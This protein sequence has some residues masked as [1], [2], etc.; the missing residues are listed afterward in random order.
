MLKRD[1]AHKLEIREFIGKGVVIP[2]LH[3]V[4]CKSSE[5][6]LFV[7]NM[8]NKNRTVGCTRMNEHSSRSHAIFSVTI[9]MCNTADDSFKVGKLNLIDLAGSERQSKTGASAERL[10]EASKINRALSALGNVISALAENSPHIPYRDS[11]LT[12]LLQDSLGGNSKTIM[13]ANISPS[14]YNYEESLTTLR[15]AHRAKTIKN[16]PIKN[17]DPKDVKLREYQEEIKRLKQLIEERKHQ[18]TIVV[19]K[20][21]KVRKRRGEESGQSGMSSPMDVLSDQE[22][23]EQELNGGEEGKRMETQLKQ[24]REK[25]EELASRLLS[26]ESQLIR[27]GKNILDAM[28]EKQIQLEQQLNEIAERKKRETEMQQMLELEEE[29]TVEFREGKFH[30]L[31]HLTLKKNSKIP[32]NYITF[33]ALLENHP[34]SK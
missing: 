6:M 19:K 28:N 20:V 25:T 10:K 9:E 27:G 4:T 7:M 32:Y 29:T 12:R 16:R 17:E 24:E 26:L 14:S 11:K 21:K 1:H 34:L 31:N 2:D 22:H 8:G 23:G 18:E 30:P 33:E 15:Y 13:I 3:T 5:E